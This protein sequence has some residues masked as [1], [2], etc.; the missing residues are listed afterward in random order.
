MV[1]Y[2]FQYYHPT[3]YKWFWHRVDHKNGTSVPL[4]RTRERANDALVRRG[5]SYKNGDT[6]WRIHQWVPKKCRTII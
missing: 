1:K 2:G 4:W 6:Q 5:W 3:M